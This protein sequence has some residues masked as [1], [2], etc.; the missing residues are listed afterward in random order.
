MTAEII[1]NDFLRNLL[2]R[3]IKVRIL[4]E[5]QHVEF[6]RSYNIRI[7]NAL[8]AGFSLDF[9]RKW[10]NINLLLEDLFRYTPPNINDRVRNPVNDKQELTDNINF[11]LNRNKRRR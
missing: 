6:G 1:S 2:L 10:A 9:V 11:I 5:K 3:R 7:K 8:G 4:A